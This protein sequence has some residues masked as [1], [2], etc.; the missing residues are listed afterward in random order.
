MLDQKY[1][2]SSPASLRT[3]PSPPR[4][5]PTLSRGGGPRAPSLTG[6][7][8]GAEKHFLFVISRS[9]EYSRF[10]EVDLMGEKSAAMEMESEGR[11]REPGVIL[12]IVAE[13]VEGWRE[14][15]RGHGTTSTGS[16]ARRSRATQAQ[17]QAQARVWA[18][19]AEARWTAPA[20]A[21]LFRENK[22]K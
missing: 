8:L 7:L 15:T 4:S 20:S 1:F 13:A 16:M 22:K 2:A 14:K 12:V 5:S 6:E 9:G 11:G 18:H 19:G 17:A 3:P 10:P 21:A